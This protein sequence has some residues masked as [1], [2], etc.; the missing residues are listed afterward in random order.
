LNPVAGISTVLFVPGS[1]PDRF[2]K[3]LA[4]GADLICID[5]ED[6][7]APDSKDAARVNAIEALKTGEPRLAIRINGLATEAGIRDLLALRETATAAI[8]LLPMV[9]SP[10]DVAI[11]AGLLAISEPRI[12]PLVES[13]AALRE[14]HLI[15]EAP[16]VAGMMFGGGDLSA[17]LGVELAWE[18][19]AVAR[20]QFVL[21]CAGRGLALIDVPF[22]K[23]EDEAGLDKESALAKAA[24]FTAKAAIH[25]AQVKPIQRM[26]RPTEGDLAEAEQAIQA[27]RAGGGKAIRHGGRMLEAPVIRRY[28]AMLASRE[29]LDA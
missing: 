4:S 8:L 10:R 27:Y 21:A 1:C 19:L 24:G 28:E 25:P 16:A 26:F 20:G 15:A 23:L 11:A 9:E 5:L 29:R 6:A 2:D 22:V 13:S 3:A 17:E 12:V 14:A 7:V 18:P